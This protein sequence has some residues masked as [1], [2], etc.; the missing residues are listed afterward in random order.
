M[1][2]LTVAIQDLCATVD[3]KDPSPLTKLK[4]T[5]VPSEVTA[6]VGLIMTEKP[7]PKLMVSGTAQL[8]ME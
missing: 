7:R 6:Q 1:A 5:T 4:V 2:Q 8:S 3:Q